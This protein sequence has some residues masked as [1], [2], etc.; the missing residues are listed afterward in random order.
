[1]KDYYLPGREPTIHSWLA[2]L[3]IFVCGVAVVLLGVLLR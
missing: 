3:M 2:P 1:M